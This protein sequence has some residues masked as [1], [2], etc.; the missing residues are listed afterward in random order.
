MVLRQEH[1]RLL[2]AGGRSLTG[3]KFLWLQGAVPEGDRALTFDELCER[4][5]KTARAC[6]HKETFIEF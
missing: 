1:R 4:N 6:T 2:E 3:T 5:L